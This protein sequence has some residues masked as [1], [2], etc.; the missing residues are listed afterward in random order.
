M[1]KIS[2]IV[3]TL[4]EENNITDC[5]KS[6]EWADEIIVIDSKSTDRTVELASKFTKKIY[7]TENLPFARKKN[8]AIEKAT[9]DW[10]LS[11]DADERVTLELKG[12]ILGIVNSADNKYDAYY[13][14]RKSF[15]INKFIKHCGWYP[16]YVLRLFK[17]SSGAKF[18]EN[19]VH[20]KL[21]VIGKIGKLDP[22]LLHYTNRNFEHYLEKL[23][24]YTTYSSN[25]LFSNG[26]KSGLIDMFFRPAFTFFKMYFLKLGFLDGYTGLVLCALSSVHVFVKYSKNY[27]LIK[28]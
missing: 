11:I 22:D 23:N 16:D 2:V 10:V 20:E 27:F 24:I 1:A 13:L 8:I 12:K 15:F 3:I 14:N 4:N 28:K 9:Y 21:L 7:L 25:E 18:S 5:L 17:K 19:L 6:V 26:K